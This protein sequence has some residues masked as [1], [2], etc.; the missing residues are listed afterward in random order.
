MVNLG[1]TRRLRK[2][3]LLGSLLVLVACSSQTGGQPGAVESS[4]QVTVA[5]P[6]QALVTRL[7]W[8]LQADGEKTAETLAIARLDLGTGVLAP[9]AQRSAEDPTPAPWN[10]V[11][12]VEPPRLPEDP[13]P[14]LSTA[15]HAVV[16]DRFGAVMLAHNVHPQRHLHWCHIRSGEP[17]RCEPAQAGGGMPVERILALQSG[18][19]TQLDLLV[20]STSGQAL[21]HLRQVWSGASLAW[22]AQSALEV[23]GSIAAEDFSVVMSSGADDMHVAWTHRGTSEVFVNTHRPGTALW[24]EARRVG[25]GTGGAPALA[26]LPTGQS[27]IFWMA[28]GGVQAARYEPGPQAWADMGAV[29]GTAGASF[30]AASGSPGGDLMFSWRGADGRVRALHHAAGSWGDAIDL[31]PAA[32]AGQWLAD[33]AGNFGITLFGAD[34]RRWQRWLAGPGWQAPQPL[35]SDA[36]DEPVSMAADTNGAV[37]VA[38]TTALTGRLRNFGNRQAFSIGRYV[39]LA[40]GPVG[41]PPDP[42]T[43]SVTVLGGGVVTSSPAGIACSADN[44]GTCSLSLQRGSEVTLMATPSSG[45]RLVAWEGDA[46]CSDG[47]VTLLSAVHCTARFEAAPGAGA[48]S[49][50]GLPLQDNTAATVRLGRNIL[51]DPQGRLYA[52]MR[53]DTSIVLQRFEAGAWRTLGTNNRSAGPSLGAGLPDAAMGAAGQVCAVWASQLASTGAPTLELNCFDGDWPTARESPATAFGAPALPREPAIRIDPLGRALVAWQDGGRIHVARR[54]A[55]GSYVAL[56]TPLGNGASRPRLAV[57]AQGDGQPVLAWVENREAR[58][59]RWDGAQWQLLGSTPGGI[60]DDDLVV[61]VAIQ[62]DGSVLVA[63][64]GKSN[65]TVFVRRH[66][67]GEWQTSG[68]FNS[69]SAGIRVWHLALDTANATAEPV[70]AWAENG[71]AL[72]LARRYRAGQWQPVG[73]FVHVSAALPEYVGVLADD[74]R[75]VVVYTRFNTPRTVEVTRFEP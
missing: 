72:V 64:G 27:W 19:P 4:P 20:R 28:A 8:Y 51:R 69:G 44:L 63:S 49:R 39:A 22:L 54:D 11:A 42:R 41:P 7:D 52:L 1:T 68:S 43:L 61:D 73:Q 37:A 65:N 59:A 14:A 47:V 74:T 36:S 50:L 15:S 29:P 9:W 35:D 67:G 30:V 46:D 26:R 3:A 32:N 10:T 38:Y 75:P 25:Q 18:N 48:W 24:S 62:A 21:Q 53:E 2:A 45:Q 34:G 31:G 5:A 12:R 23:P 71:P 40:P 55:P 58:A 13:R 60:V 56:G 57:T 6:G 66:S 33:E 16:T 17:A 70:L